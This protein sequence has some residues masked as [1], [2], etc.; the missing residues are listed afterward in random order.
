MTTYRK[1]FPSYDWDHDVA[2]VNQIVNYPNIVGVREAGF[3]KNVPN[4]EVKKNDNAIEHWIQDNMRG[5]SCF[6]L[7]VGE[8]TYQS[9]WCLYEMDLAKQM[10]IGR[11]IF[12]WMEW[13]ICEA[14]AVLW[15]LIL[16]LCTN[17]THLSCR[18]IR[19]Q[20]N[21]ITGKGMKIRM[22]FCGNGL[23]MLVLGLDI[24]Q[25]TQS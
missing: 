10:G 20:S 3:L 1:I 23:K 15:G 14:E 21:S 12:I 4:E 16:M 6:I 19:I 17:A 2:Y 22:F 24:N 7:F 18:Q 5:C 11:M 25:P 8:K 9:K 13:L